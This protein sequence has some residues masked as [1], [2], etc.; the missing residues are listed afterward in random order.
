MPR[1][2]WV[3]DDA[4]DGQLARV[5]AAVRLAIGA[6]VPD[7]LRMLSLRSDFLVP[8]R[9]AWMRLHFSDGALTR[10]Q[11]E[12]IATYV[13]AL[14]QCAYCVTGHSQLLREQG[15]QFSRT[16]QALRAGELNQAELSEGER[17][18]L[19]FVGTITKYAYRITDE[20]VQRL[21][22]VGWT[23]A[24]IAEAVYEAGLFNMIVRIADAFGLQPPAD[25]DL[26]AVTAR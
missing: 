9:E 20:Q 22:E 15:E 6:P 19:E 21:R 17:L 12:M 23:D 3:D 18:L 26:G 10:A 14:N 24:Q 5:Y 1:I 2:A 16:A 11:H 8:I 13:A 7:V 25:W 4:A